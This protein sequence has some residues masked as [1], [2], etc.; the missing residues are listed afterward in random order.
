MTILAKAIEGRE[1]IYSVR[2]AHAVPA[3]SAEKIRDIAN[4]VRYQL[5]DG[6]VWYLFDID[7]YCAAYDFALLQKFTIRNG[8]VKDCRC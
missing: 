2:S 7:Q 5:D 3:K 4:S 1:F 6:E 8:I